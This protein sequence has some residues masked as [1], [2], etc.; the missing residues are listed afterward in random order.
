MPASAVPRGLR[1]KVPLF[2]QA[3]P[4]PQS[5]ESSHAPAQ[6]PAAHASHTHPRLEHGAAQAWVRLLPGTHSTWPRTLHAHPSGCQGMRP[7]WDEAAARE[8]GR[9]P[10]V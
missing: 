6:I 7:T 1:P 2:K 5:C 4:H 10:A 9:Q 3:H 8:D